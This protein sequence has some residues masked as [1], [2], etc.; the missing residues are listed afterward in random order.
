MVGSFTF[1]YCVAMFFNSVLTQNFIVQH[2]WYIKS[3]CIL[4]FIYIISF[5]SFFH[6]YSLYNI[7]S[8]KHFLMFWW[9]TFPPVILMSLYIYSMSLCQII[10]WREAWDTYHVWGCPPH[11]H[12]SLSNSCLK[13]KFSSFVSSDY[14]VAFPF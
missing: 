5:Y 4:H 10:S 14:T 1:C 2:H 13:L 11:F 7:P 3:I 12:D 8:Q 6:V 9:Q